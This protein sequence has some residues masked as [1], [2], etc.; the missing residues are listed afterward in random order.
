MPVNNCLC[1]QSLTCSA[2]NTEC[3]QLLLRNGAQLNAGIER[4]SPLHYAVERNHVKC[5]QTLLQYGAN[6]NTPQV[7][8]ETPLH[9]A[10]YLG[11]EQCIR[12]LLD[13]GA[14]VRSQF[15][16]RR[17]TALHL[18][19]EED[20]TECARLLLDAG[21]LIDVR[22]CYDQTPLHIACLIQSPETL[23]L[24]IKRNSDVHSVY[25]DG[26]TALHAAI[27]KDSK[28]WE[29]AQ[30]LLKAGVDVNRSDNYGYTPL[31]LAALNEYSSCVK[32]LIGGWLPTSIIE[33]PKKKKQNFILQSSSVA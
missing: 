25:K 27:V 1:I 6:P 20:Y 2:G 21:A 32:M 17:A 14:D 10:A 5:V 11:F 8:T 9:V 26:R 19:V 33:E 31:H 12:L 16:K 28:T 29:C 23:G 15:G 22:N 18:A 3:I 13:H 30:M 7:Y 24:L 4:R